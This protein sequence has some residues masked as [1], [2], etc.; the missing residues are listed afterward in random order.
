MVSGLWVIG[1]GVAAVILVIIAFYWIRR[2]E[3][4]W[5]PV[6]I[7]F[8]A[9]TGFIAGMELIGLA[10][11]GI[12]RLFMVSGEVLQSLEPTGGFGPWLVALLATAIIL[13]I[14]A[15]YDFLLLRTIVVSVLAG[16]FVR[17]IFEVTTFAMQFTEG[18][19]M[20]TAFLSSFGLLL[21]VA[22]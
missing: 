17:I 19:T 10:L 5:Q 9:L 11:F 20:P 2:V 4:G 12:G 18:T 22:A 21:G 15:K 8:S 3:S 1:G 16:I 14:V 13:G 7:I 6:L